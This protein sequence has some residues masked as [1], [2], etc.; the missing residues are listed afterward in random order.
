MNRLARLLTAV[1]SSAVLLVAG[2][3]TT[4]TAAPVATLG[5]APP[6]VRCSFFWNTSFADTCFESD[7]DDQWIR[8]LVANGWAAVVHV[9]LNYLKDRTC[10]AMPAAEGWGVC[11]FDHVEDKCVRF[12]LYEQKGDAIRNRT[13]WSR[14]FHVNGTGYCD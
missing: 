14:W 1:L 7:G 3:A 10:K 2:T 5:D 13:H 6:G 9:Q 4:A 8:D 11:K 12:Q